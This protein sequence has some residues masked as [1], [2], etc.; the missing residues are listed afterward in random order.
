MI[1]LEDFDLPHEQGVFG[2][3]RRHDVHTGIDFYCAPA[4]KVRAFH[5]GVVTR[6]GPFTGPV[7]GTP[8][9]KDTS[10]VAI[11]NE[12]L[13]LTVL[14]GEVSAATEVEVGQRCSRGDCIGA[15]ATVLKTDKG[16]PRTMLHLECYR[17]NPFEDPEFQPK[18][19]NLG[20]EQL[21][22]LI[23]PASVIPEIYR[24]TWNPQWGHSMST[25]SER[26]HDCLPDSARSVRS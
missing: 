25:Y 21:A 18:E 14:Y 24:L 22:Y 23:D 2:A 11:Y 4:T 17:G 12:R 9:W 15:V 8:W 5:G 3:V 6:I 13:Y 1:V 10:F 20:E 19:W 26:T 16:L 7:A